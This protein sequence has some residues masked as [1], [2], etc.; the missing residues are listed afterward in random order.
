MSQLGSIDEGAV[1]QLRQSRR[2][3]GDRPG[4]FVPAGTPVVVTR[5]EGARIF[6]KPEVGP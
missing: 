3:E 1:L 2:D 5:V 6:V 4:V